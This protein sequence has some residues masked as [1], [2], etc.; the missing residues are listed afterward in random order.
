MRIIIIKRTLKF[1]L[2]TL[3][4]QVLQIEINELLKKLEKYALTS[5]M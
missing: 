1:L 4:S 3:G 2:L 5:I